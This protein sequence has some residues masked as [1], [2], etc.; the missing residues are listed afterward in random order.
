MRLFILLILLIN[1]Q[2]SHTPFYNKV[3]SDYRENSYFVS[4]N[5]K[6]KDYQGQIV[7]PN[8]VLYRYIKKTK[9][10]DKLKYKSFIRKNIMDDKTIEVNKNIFSEK[11]ILKV[12]NKYFEQESKEAIISKYFTNNVLNYNVSNEIKSVIISKL[13]RLNVC[14]LI[15][16]ESGALIIIE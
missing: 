14:C 10:Y 13:F 5:I 8:G 11:Y 6:T 3:L 12:N 4:I 16:D 1:V 9:R 2:Q 15:E 7:I